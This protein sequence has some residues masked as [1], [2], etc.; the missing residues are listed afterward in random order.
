MQS[1]SIV[2][3]CA[4][5]W[6]I[7]PLLGCADHR[8]S[9]DE[10]LAM[11]QQMRQAS[12]TSQ[13][14]STQP[15]TTQPVTSQPETTQPDTLADR[16][17][18]PYHVGPS[19]V[20]IVT[21]TTVAQPVATPSVQA[22]V[23]RDG[24]V[25]LPMVGKVK[26]AGLALEDVER[27]I[28]QAYAP[29]IFREALIHVEVMAPD[30]TEVLVVGAVTAPGLIRLRRT[31]R[32]LLYAI[33]GAGGVSNIASGKVTLKRVRRPGEEVTLTL[34]E[35]DQLRA[36]LT[37][38]PLERGDI[39][40]VHAA[41]PNAIFVGGLV[42]AP[43]PQVYPQGVTM[44]VLQ[45]LAAS[46]GLRVDVTPREATLIRRM[47]DGRD[48]HVRLNLDRL[49]TGRDPNIELAAGDILWVPD[50]LETRCQ[51]WFN[52]NIFFR[53]GVGLTANVNYNVEGLDYLNNNAR[54]AQNGGTGGG[55]TQDTF[56]PFG[57]L[58]RNNALQNITQMQQSTP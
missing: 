45:A 49:T 41:T 39:V 4:A 34:T 27:T 19:D 17:L 35:P 22:R 44:T 12:P 58:T 32:N 56:D 42:A 50:T 16:F 11:Q 7:V 9:L 48:V 3:L 5:L 36:S 31:E 21:L 54:Q 38:P 24:D 6:V 13:P 46:G 55:S 2:G 57:Y 30:N 26:V 51:D 8:I 53:A 1:P 15:S 23:N 40:T 52:R 43:R 33:V 37:L 29:K 25:E 14:A 10:F 20:L 18:E 28:Q 47:P